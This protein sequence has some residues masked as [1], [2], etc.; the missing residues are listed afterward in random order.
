MAK[1]R[2]SRHEAYAQLRATGVLPSK[3][4]PAAGYSPR[5]AVYVV[6]DRDPNIVERIAELSEDRQRVRTS[7]AA[8]VRAT[9]ANDIDRNW[10]LRQL[11]RTVADATEAGRYKD[12]TAALKI[13]AQGLGLLSRNGATAAVVRSPERDAVIEALLIRLDSNTLLNAL[14][15]EP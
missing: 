9:E 15:A 11:V 2:N 10:V 3:A 13:M 12:A 1:L 14:P 5:S 7:E 6:L 8:L 4:A